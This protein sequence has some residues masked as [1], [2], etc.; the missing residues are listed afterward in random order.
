[1][2]LSLHHYNCKVTYH[3]KTFLH[4]Y[5][6]AS[7]H[8][9][10]SNLTRKRLKYIKQSAISDHLLQCNCATNFDD[11]NIFA[12]DFNKF[13]CLL[14]ESLFMNCD[15]LLLKSTTKLFLPELFDYDDSFI[16]NITRTWSTR[17]NLN[18]LF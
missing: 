14:R 7:E 11:F 13:K 15:K 16:A 17:D 2:C 3:R 4:C 5:T 1:M 18:D 10:I 9:G 6:R 8:M 12:T